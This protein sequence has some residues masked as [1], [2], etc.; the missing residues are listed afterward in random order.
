MTNKKTVLTPTIKIALIAGALILTCFG[1][2]II[3]VFPDDPNDDSDKSRNQSDFENNAE[4]E[5]LYDEL[6]EN[7]AQLKEL[8]E[9]DK[10]S[11]I[12]VTKSEFLRIKDGMSYQQVKDI[13]GQSGEEM[14]R[15]VIDGVPG[16]LER[17][18][19][20]MYMWTNPDGSNMNAMF[21]N[22]SLMQ[23]SQFGLE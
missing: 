6:D 8:L 10:K 15:N 18:E 23:K 7:A 20:V 13:I 11:R 12:V 3:S 14:S 19:T 17:T 16:V 22:D 5:R 4:L 1:G 9:E 21:Q 2:I